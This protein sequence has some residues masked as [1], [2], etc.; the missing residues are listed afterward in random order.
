MNAHRLLLLVASSLVACGGRSVELAGDSPAAPGGSAPSSS[1]SA[2]PSPSGAPTTPVVP[3]RAACGGL[4]AVVYE[5]STRTLSSLD[6]RTAAPSLLGV[7]SC[8][9][10][11]VE[12]LTVERSGAIVALSREGKMARIDAKAP[13]ACTALPALPPPAASYRGAI[14]M[15]DTGDILTL[16]LGTSAQYLQDGA[17]HHELVRV[18]PDTGVDTVVA[19]YDDVTYPD[20]IQPGSDGRILLVYFGSNQVRVWEP[21]KSG[22]LVRTDI[23]GLGKGRA[24]A[25]VPGGELMVL[26]DVHDVGP[27]SVADALPTYLVNPSSGA[28]VR[29]ADVVLPS[30]GTFEIAMGGTACTFDR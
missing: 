3:P 23:A 14:P 13:R 24:G 6:G 11:R 12:A 16:R 8:G 27:S 9:D 7:V 19:T 22:A 29:G 1:A 15:P 2:A 20:A 25:V 5:R 30:R 4:D 10:M 17:Y 28:L 21:W 26:G 18:T